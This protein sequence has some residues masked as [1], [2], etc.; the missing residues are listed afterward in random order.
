MEARYYV[1]LRKLQHDG[2]VK[3][4]EMQVRYLLQEGY[5]NKFTGKKVLPIYYIPDFVITYSD[6]HKLV[7]D[8]KGAEPDA[9][10]LK[11]KMF[12][13]KYPEIDFQCIQ[14]YGKVGKWL[15]LDEIKKL[16]KASKEP[17]PTVK[18]KRKVK[19]A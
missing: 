15:P 3:D 8:V 1:Y 4:F 12:G 17:A 13:Y 16:K 10:L 18:R 14:W 5:T 9:F 2:E 11:K 6:G 19:A 7:V